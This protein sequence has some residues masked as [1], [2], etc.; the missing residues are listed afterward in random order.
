[1]D[2]P[3]YIS[4]SQAVF[5]E[6]FQVKEVSGAVKGKNIPVPKHCATK[7]KL[8]KVTAQAVDEG[9]WSASRSRGFTSQG[10]KFG[11][12]TEQ[13]SFM[14]CWRSWKYMYF[15]EIMSQSLN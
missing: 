15:S 13:L 14:L 2:T 3:S 10:W 9:E 4:G 11:W 8:Q 12:P 6:T 1:L 7:I 5:L